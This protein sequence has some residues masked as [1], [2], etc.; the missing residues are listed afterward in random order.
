[1][2]LIALL[3]FL[4]VLGLAFWAVQALSGALGIPPPILTVIQVLLVVIAVLYLLQAFNL[5]GE[6]SLVNLRLGR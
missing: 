5:I 1:M 3:V 6:G 2:P 4:I